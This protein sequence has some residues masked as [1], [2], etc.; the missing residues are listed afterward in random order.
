M[1]AAV[2][3]VQKEGK[4]LRETTHLC[5]LPL[6]SLRRQVIGSVQLNCRPGPRTV[7]T[8]EEERLA[9]YLIQM[10]EMG[11][12]ISREGVMG[13]AYTIVERLTSSRKVPSQTLSLKI[14]GLIPTYLLSVLH[15]LLH[16]TSETCSFSP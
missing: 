7:L 9:A 3:S 10:S 11:Y 8:E 14:A 5:N 15:S 13:M 4:G 1:A 6:E 2:Y 12:E 16:S